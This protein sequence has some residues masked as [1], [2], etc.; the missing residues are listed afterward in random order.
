MLG[1]GYP[2]SRTS[3]EEQSFNGIGLSERKT[4][5]MLIFR[6]IRYLT[7][8]SF[9]VDNTDKRKLLPFYTLSHA[10]ML[11]KHSGT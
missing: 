9:A 3:P 7:A 8:H 6:F 1:V 5:L 2:D 11:R 10:G 4:S